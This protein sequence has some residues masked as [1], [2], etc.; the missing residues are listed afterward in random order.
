MSLSVCVARHA[1]NTQ[2]EKFAISLPYL[3]ENI[4]DEVD[5]FLPADK[6][7]MFL[8]FDAVVLGLCGQA[9]QNYSK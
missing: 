3:K 4:K 8:Q 9:C 5:H 2:N 6:H 7:Q 1:Q